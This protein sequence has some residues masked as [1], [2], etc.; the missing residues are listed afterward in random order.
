[1]SNILD[2]NADN[3]QQVLGEVSQQKLVALVFWTPQSPE[4]VAQIATFERMM[5]DYG[6]YLVLAKLNCDNEQALASQLAQQI[7]LQTIPTTVLLKDAGP[8]DLLSGQQTE[9]QLKDSLAK[10]LPNRADILLESAKKALLADDHNQAFI[11]AK[12]AYELDASNSKIKLVFADICVNIKKLDEAKALLATILENEQD[13][14][15]L[16]IASKLEYAFNQF[17]SPEIK[18]LQQQ[19]EEKPDDLELKVKLAHVLDHA[20]RK[21]EAL[22]ILFNVL[23]KQLSFGDAKKDFLAII[24]SLPSGDSI[25]TQYRR[26]LYSILY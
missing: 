24:D 22:E 23:K 14:Y 12:Q 3:F 11:F 16:N 5:S 1:M 26:K 9:Q 20:G 13:P 25:A 7:G 10:H 2:L 21:A 17:D 19:V 6:D 4:C 15:F 18:Q 8:V